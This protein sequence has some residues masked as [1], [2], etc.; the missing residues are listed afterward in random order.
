LF[1]KRPE[2]ATARRHLGD[3]NSDPFRSIKKAF[4]AILAAVLVGCT[5]STPYQ[6]FELFGRGGYADT[7]I[8]DDI[9]RVSF[10]GSGAT[11]LQAMHSMLL[12]RT[13]EITLNHGFD[14]FEVL[15]RRERIPLSA[16]DG[17]KTAEYTVKLRLCTIWGEPEKFGAALLRERIANR[18]GVI[19]FVGLWGPYDP[20]G[21]I[22]LLC[23]DEL[24]RLA[25][26][27]DHVYWHAVE[28][29]F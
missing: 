29:W 27:G 17:F 25:C 7:R 20:Q 8:S 10:Y 15:S 2:P 13:A 3:M 21:H 6:A 4:L 9:Y 24:H 18:R 11:N 23:H 16:R 26:E 14:Y 5:M 22:D 19:R 12:Y 1:V 28:C